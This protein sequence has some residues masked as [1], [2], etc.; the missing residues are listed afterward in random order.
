MAIVA[1]VALLIWV[2]LLSARGRFWLFRPV[3]EDDAPPPADAK[4][5][6][7]VVMPARNEADAVGAA[8]SSLLTPNCASPIH[9]FLVDDHSQ[10]GT[11]AIA[12]AA[13]REAG[14]ADRLTVISAPPLEPGWT[15]KLWAVSNGIAAASAA[16]P[17]YFL[18]TDADIVHAESSVARLVARA[19]RERLDLASVMVRL[20]CRTLPERFTIPAFVFFFFLLYPP[21]WIAD[22]RKRTSGAAG[23]S[24]LIRPA[25]LASIGGIA[26]I[27]GEL[28]DDCALARR[29]K[30]AG[31]RLWLGLSR[32]TRSVRPYGTLGDVREMI[33]RTAFTQL[34]HS[35][36]LLGG[37]V[38]GMLLTYVAPPLL[39]L[40]GPSLSARLLGAAAWLLM[41]IAFA[42]ALSFYGQPVWLAPLLPLTA[43]FYSYATLDSA[44]RYWRGAGGQW[45]GR[46]QDTKRGG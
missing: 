9:V 6:I 46:V 10:D 45:K 35:T 2:I 26:A 4:T 43:V 28:I 7:A 42:P 23:G 30:D 29:V 21:A 37:T 27:R 25:A 22:P 40:V 17:D 18:L 8:V 38:I 5:S 19:E 41:S 16:R 12:R 14:A 1:A 33:S 32:D 13:A 20:H 15:G 24:I 3:I 11:A 34:G 31:G 44:F 36:L 39:L